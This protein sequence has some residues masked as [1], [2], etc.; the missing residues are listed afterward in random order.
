[1]G[2]SF[3]SHGNFLTKE[4]TKFTGPERYPWLLRQLVEKLLKTKVSKRFEIF[5]QEWGCT[6]PLDDKPYQE[7]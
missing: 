4:A 3:A 5:A 2:R 7:S 6:R 1:M